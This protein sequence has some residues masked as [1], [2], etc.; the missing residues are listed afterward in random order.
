MTA[1]ANNEAWGV[2]NGYLHYSPCAPQCEYCDGSATN[3]MSCKD[4]N[5]RRY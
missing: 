5:A 1:D 2:F 3:C 4:I